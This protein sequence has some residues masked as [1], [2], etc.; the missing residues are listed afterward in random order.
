[1]MLACVRVRVAYLIAGY[2]KLN[3]LI[4]MNAS[5]NNDLYSVIPQ[6]DVENPIVF[7]EQALDGLI[8]PPIAIQEVVGLTQN[9]HPQQM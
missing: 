5:S 9:C 3:D 2:F 1:M 4:K 8:M 7:E 6:I